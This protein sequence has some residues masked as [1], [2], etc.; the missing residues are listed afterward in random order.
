MNVVT[1]GERLRLVVTAIAV[2]AAVSAC[3]A[4]GTTA[5]PSPHPT[6]P[7]A[8]TSRLA[9]SVNTPASEPGSTAAP[10]SWAGC[11][12]SVLPGAWRSALARG[13]VPRTTG[14]LLIPLAFDEATGDLFL[15]VD[16]PGSVNQIVRRSQ[17]ADEVLLD[18][19]T[20]SELQV[21]AAHWDGRRLAVT[22]T[23]SFSDMSAFVNRVWDSRTHTWSTHGRSPGGTGAGPAPYQVLTGGTLWW[24]QLNPRRLNQADV[25]RTDLAT[26]QDTIVNR[27]IDSGGAPVRLGNLLIWTQVIAKTNRFHAATL[28]GHATELPAALRSATGMNEYA[29]DGR[30]IAWLTT[31]PARVW[32]WRDGWTS[33]RSVTLE[34][35][36]AGGLSVSGELVGL[37]DSQRTYGL[38]LRSGVLGAL[39]PQWGGVLSSGRRLAVN[40][41]P[42]SKASGSDLTVLDPRK[43]PPLAC[44]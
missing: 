19:G 5:L 13:R 14:E 18:L 25:H 40:Y 16:R 2:A 43:L 24:T 17:G 44:G 41:A 35:E 23:T 39:T 7:G 22:I 28:Q 12:T 26:G 9:S 10:A 3:S 42:T 8:T 34:T 27:S 6:S 33:P 30:T 38:D 1:S 4:T 11:R 31:F 15:R 36:A 32:A 20:G 37:T 29:T 21:A